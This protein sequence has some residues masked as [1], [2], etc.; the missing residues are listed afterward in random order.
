MSKAYE[1]II[2]ERLVIAYDNR[3]YIANVIVTSKLSS[4]VEALYCKIRCFYSKTALIR[5]FKTKYYIRDIMHP[6]V[7]LVKK[8][9][10]LIRAIS[11]KR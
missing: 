4:I 10:M 9:F 7:G 3:D 5:V 2:Y 6:L 1:D 11:R 8:S